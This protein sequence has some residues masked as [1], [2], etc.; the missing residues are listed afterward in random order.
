MF[1]V[2]FIKYFMWRDISQVCFEF[3]LW[4]LEKNFVVCS[5]L[6]TIFRAIW[7]TNWTNSQN[8]I[9][10]L[11]TMSFGAYFFDWI[12][13]KFHSYDNNNL[14]EKK[15]HAKELFRVSDKRSLFQSVYQ[16]AW[17]SLGRLSL[18]FECMWGQ[19]CLCDFSR[20]VDFIF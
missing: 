9:H 3:F 6:N 14:L 18:H 19:F 11:S 5:P 7:Q 2:F 10:Q 16:V 20:L 17:L 4:R 12:V 8:Q 1:C 15:I 13:K